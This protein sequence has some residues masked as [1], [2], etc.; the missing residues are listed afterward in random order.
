MASMTRAYEV[1]RNGL[2]HPFTDGEVVVVTLAAVIGVWT[3]SPAWV[4]AVAVASL[5]VGR[6]SAV[7]LACLVIGIAGGW[8][9]QT[10]WDSAVPRHVGSYTGWV[11]IVGDP[12]PFGSGLR[13]TIGVGGERFDAWAYGSPRR[14]LVDRQ[15][16]EM[17]F[18]QGRRRLM[19]S[20]ARRAQIRHVVGQFD[21]G[22]VGDWR[23]GSPLYRT[24]SRVRSAL[25]HAA[26]S[27]MGGDDA[28]L[29]TGLVIGDDAREPPAM[30]DA[31]R[32]SGLSHLTAV[33]GE[34]VAFV[35]AAASPLLRRLRSWWRWAATLGL[36]GW[37]MTL[38]RFE[39]SVLRAG[40]MAMLACSSFVLGRQQAVVRVL[41]L[42]VTIL[43]LV[44][45]M[46]VWSVG[47]WLSTGATAGVCVI[48]PLVADLLPGPQWIRTPLSVTLGAQLGVMLPSWLV[49]HR[50]PLVSL[51]ANL[52][53][54]PVAGFVMLLGIPG[55]LLSAVVTPLAP[56]IMAPCAAG[57]RWVN[58]IAY[59]AAGLEPSPRWSA[60]GWAA[61]AVTI[62][63]LV[64]RHRWRRP[65]G[66]VPI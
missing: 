25:R 26:E 50:L 37:F 13:V 63:A 23:E 9:S 2:R 56:L 8:R 15:A 32:A 19:V 10:T 30:I 60:L 18:V 4:G 27:T 58:T 6:R 52:L 42:T 24:S 20:N 40:I 64:I 66:D 55:G 12:A 54:V 29:F 44:D 41:A 39:P 33:S 34:N 1:R 14:R 59:L 48:A 22:V 35:L 3:R 11:V 16:G 28:A 45:P 62:V 53:A 17:V 51:P 47:F 36:I 43:V 7:L 21:L 46:L 57:T 31:F 61:V 5:A 49:F 38:T 65:P